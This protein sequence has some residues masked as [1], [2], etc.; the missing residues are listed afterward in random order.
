[1]ERG[2]ALE[3]WRGCVNAW[4]CDELGHMNMRFYLARAFDGLAGLAA[5]LGQP[6]AFA[7]EAAAT[8]QVVRQH[9][10]FLREAKAGDSLFMS[11]GVAEMQEEGALAL[12]VLHHDDGR[13]CATV[14]S[15][16]LHATPKRGRAFCWPARALAAAENLSVT[17]PEFAAPRNFAQDEPIDPTLAWS[18]SLTRIGLAPVAARDCDVFGYMTPDGV[19]AR[20]S[21]GMNQLT[22]PLYAEIA[23]AEPER[24][25]GT[26]ALEYRIDH[27][28]RPRA[29]D[30]VDVR[31]RV[32]ALA[33]KVILLEHWL[34]DPVERRVWA[35]AKGVCANFDL[36]TR[37]AAP[38]PEAVRSRFALTA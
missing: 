5:A 13:P 16:L 22:A 34:C 21:D 15:H 26:A 33:E 37:R 28:G 27:L 12:Q 38:I 32:T 10:R 35:R 19:L 7:T 4:E 24:R 14:L 18:Q 1:M 25:L 29:G 17:V 20:V 30:L 23:A 3:V 2:E 9:V 6:R 8:L 36:D 11:G 31:S